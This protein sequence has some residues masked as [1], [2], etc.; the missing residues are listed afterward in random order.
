MTVG[1]RGIPYDIVEV[2]MRL[3]EEECGG[4]GGGGGGGGSCEESG[5][6]FTG[7]NDVKTYHHVI[8][9]NYVYLGL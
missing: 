7:P 4:G 9:H 1:V 3:V 2:A 6:L 5:T 8:N